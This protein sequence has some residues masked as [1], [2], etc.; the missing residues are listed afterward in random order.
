MSIGFDWQR[1]ATDIPDVGYLVA[2]GDDACSI[3]AEPA[4]RGTHHPIFAAAFCRPI[5]AAQLD[6]GKGA[7]HDLVLWG[8]CWQPCRG[9]QAIEK[10]VFISYRRTNIA[11]ALAIFQNLTQ[12]GYDVFIDYDGIASGNFEAAILENIRARAHFLIL[13]T[14]TALEGSD[15]P[16]DWMR[17]EIE[18]A[19]YNQR[20]IVPLMLDGFKFDTPDL[21]NQL[22]G[23]LE[24]LK[25]Y[26]GLEIPA[27]FFA[28]AMDRL[29]TKF[30]N[31]PIDSVLHSASVSAQEIATEQ[32]GRAEMALAS[33]PMGADLTKTPLPLMIEAARQAHQE[34]EPN[35]FQEQLTP[36]IPDPFKLQHN[37]L[38]D[39]IKNGLLVPV[40]GAD[41][42]L[43]GRPLRK[44]TP[45][46]W[47]E[48]L[49]GLKF[50]PTTSELA[51][52]LLNEAKNYGRPDPALRQLLSS[53]SEKQGR[54]PQDSMSQL[55]LA[56]VSQYIQFLNR[57]ILDVVL[58]DI[59]KQDFNLTPVHEFL[60]KFSQ[61]KP[62]KKIDRPYP[63]IVTTCLDQVLERL[64]RKNDVPFHLVAFVLSRKGGAFQY[65]APGRSPEDSSEEISVDNIHKIYESD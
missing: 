24:A 59:L 3:G 43:C 64:L 58:P 36:L 41:I 35:L 16:K 49:D 60:L 30:L 37:I 44:R 6:L 26:N 23:R 11:W 50:P 17:R 40:L 2:R 27:I 21:G 42:N 45:I 65:T 47:Q 12:Y 13:L 22:T 8:R 25:Q 48:T 28:E 4:V 51:S 46:N 15:D 55:S 9:Q 1:L 10:T 14:P 57:D 39:D 54:D 34:K 62:D 18:A 38:L 61:Y 52:Y 7:C 29:R 53:F 5:G 31:V 33:V 56:N 20:N 32:K 63:C 19:L